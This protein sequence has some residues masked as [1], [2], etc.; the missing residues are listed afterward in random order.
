[1]TAKK[2]NK[3]WFVYAFIATI[4]IGVWGAV[5]GIPIEHG[6]SSSF[7]FLTW[8]LA[9]FITSLI[10][11]FIIHFKID[12]SK[13]TSLPA[14]LAGILGAGGQL[15]LFNALK[16]GPA[17]IIF[18]IISL[19][20]ILTVVMSMF[21]LNE[22]ASEKSII[23]VVLALLAIT[24]ISISNSNGG[25]SHGLLWLLLAL[26]TFVCWGVQGYFMKFAQKNANNSESV[27]I[28]VALGG[29]LLVP[30][31]FGFAF[32]WNFSKDAMNK[33]VE[34]VNWGGDGAI[35][36]FLVQMLNAVAMLFFVYALREGKAMIVSP[37][38]NA[39]GPVLTVI[40][41]LIIYNTFP[42]MIQII[43]ILAALYA[44]FLLSK[45]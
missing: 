28:Y 4:F 20:P 12:L 17:Y 22:K 25:E 18:P 14:L 38:V 9:M 19:A 23:G 8:A 21:L 33:L 26:G 27:Y 29:L 10:A 35:L 1:M 42:P 15:F 16:E 39:I 6:F 44:V 43:G 5:S 40:I 36:S 3:R 2:E 7:V 13:K 32:E 34:T 11:L 41:S 24:L 31:A 37:M 45:D 30:L